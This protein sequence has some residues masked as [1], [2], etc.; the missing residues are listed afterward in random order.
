MRFSKSKTMKDSDVE[1]QRFYILFAF[2]WVAMSQ[3]LVWFTFSAV[4]P[5][6]VFSYYGIGRAELDREFL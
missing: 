4:E 6:V 2:S 5:D 1:A 3:C